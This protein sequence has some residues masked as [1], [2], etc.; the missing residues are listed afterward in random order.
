MPN[1]PHQATAKSGPHLSARLVTQL[2]RRSYDEMDV[3][4]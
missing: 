4:C 1:T 3:H 2:I